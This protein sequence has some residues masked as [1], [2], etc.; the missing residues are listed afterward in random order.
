MNKS[1]QLLSETRL[2]RR[3]VKHAYRELNYLR[4]KLEGVQSTR[5]STE[6]LCDLGDVVAEVQESIRRS[7]EQLGQPVPAQHE[8][9]LTIDEELE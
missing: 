9:H 4:S 7:L 1:N 5:L 3:T 2:L 6:D 8:Q